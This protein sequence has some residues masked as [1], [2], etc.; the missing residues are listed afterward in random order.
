MIVTNPNEP[1]A[2][3]EP[4]NR[5]L[6]ARQTQ[7]VALLMGGLTSKQIAGALGLKFYTV[8]T[9]MKNIYKKLGVSN[10]SSLMVKVLTEGVLLESAIPSF[11]INSLELPENASL[12]ANRPSR[13]F[14]LIELLVV[15]AIIA[16]LAA[17]LLPA[18]AKAKDKAKM[19]RC[20]SN[21]KQIGLAYQMY[22]QD[23]DNFLPVAGLDYNGNVSPV[24]WFLQISPYVARG[25]T[26]AA[27]LSATNSVVACPSAKID[28]VMNPSDPNQ[29]AYGGYGHNYYYLG[30]TDSSKIRLT[31][32]SKPVETCMNGDGLDPIPGQALGYWCFGYLYTP[33]NPPWASTGNQM[34][35][36]PPYTRH[37]IGDNF[38]WADGHTVMTP[39]RIMSAGQNGLRD[40]FYLAKK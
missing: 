25:T 15:I 16:I 4:D 7:V 30:Y 40:W 18:L 36:C 38:A 34:S 39:W 8:T 1:P 23:N 14:T 33:S 12:S 20:T 31:D 21:E 13:G 28:G 2:V 29:S 37:G 6:T 17:M 32:I 19:I 9:H 3:T 35:T 22:A 27:N 11:R 10:R 5:R 24:G 26:N